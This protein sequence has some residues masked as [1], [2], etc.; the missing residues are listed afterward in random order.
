MG[1]ELEHRIDPFTVRDALI[2]HDKRLNQLTDLSH[3]TQTIVRGFEEQMKTLLERIN[4]G[5]SPT[6]Q[7]IKDQN[8]DLKTQIVEFKGDVNTRFKEME[9]RLN[10]SD[11][12][13]GT[14]IGEITGWL[15]SFKGLIWKVAGGLILAAILGLFG[16]YSYVHSIKAEIDPLIAILNKKIK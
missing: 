1:D 3:E 15:D 5:V 7:A 4:K 9:G 14:Q 2:L 13:F 8:A 11:E 16:M 12:H 6:M 10:V